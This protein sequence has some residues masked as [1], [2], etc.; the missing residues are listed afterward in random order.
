M[1]KAKVFLYFPQTICLKRHF[2]A[3]TNVYSR[4]RHATA[5]EFGA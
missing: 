4:N 1:F 3:E 2:I 5:F